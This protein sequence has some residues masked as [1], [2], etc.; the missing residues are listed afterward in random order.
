MAGRSAPKIH[1]FFL[2]AGPAP[3]ASRP[4]VVDTDTGVDD[5]IAMLILLRAGAQVEPVAVV[6]VAGNVDVEAATRNAA[7]VLR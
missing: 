3:P 6:S 2:M 1:F 5:A 4:V 7:A